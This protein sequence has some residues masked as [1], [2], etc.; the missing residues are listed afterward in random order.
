MPTPKVKT[1]KYVRSPPVRTSVITGKVQDFAGK[2]Q[3]G[4]KGFTLVFVEYKGKVYAL[5]PK[6]HYDS[7]YD[8]NLRDSWQLVGEPHQSS[9]GRA[10]QAR[11]VQGKLA[12]WEQQA[13]D[14]KLYEV[15]AGYPN[16]AGPNWLHEDL[17]DN[18]SWSWTRGDAER[19][20]GGDGLSPLAMKGTYSKTTQRSLVKS[21]IAR[22]KKKGLLVDVWNKRA[23]EEYVAAAGGG[24]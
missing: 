11:A 24:R 14:A 1:V 13:L 3:A 6:G 23:G 20:G 17:F 10:Q 2:Q 22:M 15:I 19:F 8:A 12:P 16:G 5:T 7:H 4:Q 18:H 21:A 9:R